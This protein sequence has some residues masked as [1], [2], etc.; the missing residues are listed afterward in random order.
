MSRSGVATRYT[1]YPEAYVSQIALDDYDM[2]K[3]PGRTY[4]YYTGKPLFEYGQGLSYTT[5]GM[6]CKCAGVCS[7]TPMNFSCA[8][9]NTGAV[10]GDEVVMV[11]HQAGDAIRTASDHPI[12]LKSLV[13]FDRVTLAP[14]AST[15]ITFTLLEAAFELTT[16]DG[17]KTV[18]PGQR[19]IVF[20]RG[21]G[22]DVAIP[23]TL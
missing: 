2:T 14:G 19:N 13:Q 21:T 1:I 16:T 23:I 9:S 11:F 7:A 12:P 3:A 18:I 17:N 4:R 8:V 15:T 6:Q 20:S 5:F 10:A 22:N